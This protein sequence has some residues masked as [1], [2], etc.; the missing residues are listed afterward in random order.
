MR[1]DPRGMNTT[2]TLSLS[3][4]RFLQSTVATAGA[5]AMP[6]FLRPDRAR[7]ASLAGSEPL[8]VVVFLRGGADGLALVP[9]LGDPALRAARKPLVPE[10]AVDIGAGFALHPALAPLAPLHREGRLAAVQAVGLPDP[11]RSHFD[12]QDACERGGARP[13]HGMEGWLA[14]ALA[15]G[16]GG[17]RVP[18]VAL[19]R[20]R[21]L[22]LDGDPAALAFESLHELRSPARSPA[23]Q[24]ALEGLFVERASGATAQV[25]L[26]GREALEVAALV[27][28][29][30]GEA[31][32]GDPRS[33]RREGGAG[34]A[35]RL[36]HQLDTLA[37]LARADLG[38]TAAWVDVQGWDTHV[39]QGNEDGALARHAAGLADAL[40]GF[41][42]SLGPRA[43]DLLLLVL[44]EFGRTLAPNGSGGTDHG[45]ASV[46]LALGGAVAGGRVLG[47]WPGLGPGALEDGRDL[48]VTTDVRELLAE[49]S[50]HL[51]ARDLGVVLP[52]YDPGR[53]GL[54][55]PQDA[56]YPLPGSS[57]PL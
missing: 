53:L 18:A 15:D 7:A 51:G 14:R 45:R 44:T 25:A 13:G 52:G 23:A 22:A 46:A 16:D 29:R 35:A 54:L 56:R 17:G 24:R 2:T 43:A 50:R 1:F 57:I 38:L 39:N 32:R 8:L 34:G 11:V 19:S 20:G 9:P 21:P 28:A 47:R 36:G 48:R 26:A 37:R 55:K 6:I 33:R 40:A 30:A 10:H 31:S 5:L 41:E 42:D 12:A 49:A 27:R 3:R 4:R